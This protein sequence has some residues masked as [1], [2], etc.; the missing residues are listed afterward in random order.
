M[1]ARSPP[2]RASTRT[3]S[4]P[5]CSTGRATP[6]SSPSCAARLRHQLIPDGDVAGVIAVTDPDTGDRH[7]YG[8]GRR[9]RGRAGGGGAALRR[10]P[11]PGPAAVPQRRRARRAA[12]G[13]SRTSTAST[14]SRTGQ[15]RLHLRRDRGHRRLAARGG[16]APQGLHHHRKRGDARLDRHRAL[17]LGRATTWSKGSATLAAGAKLQG[18]A[19]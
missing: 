10:R 12:A 8:L 17:G 7:L 11:V 2:P 4:S 3:R 18:P 9:A 16:Q 13:A 14:G 1:S 19:K 15:G 6:S 5:A